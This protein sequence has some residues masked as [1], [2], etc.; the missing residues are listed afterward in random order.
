ML[1]HTC[2]A[3]SNASSS[4][5][6]FASK[7][8]SHQN[9]ISRSLQS[10]SGTSGVGTAT[11]IA[12]GGRFYVAQQSGPLAHSVGIIR[13]YAKVVRKL[14]SKKSS[15]SLSEKVAAANSPLELPKTLEEN[16]GPITPNDLESWIAKGEA[17]DAARREAELA[18]K[19]AEEEEEEDEFDDEDF[20]E[21]SGD[22]RDVNPYAKYKWIEEDGPEEIDP[23]A[24]W[25]RQEGMEKKRKR[26]PPPF[27]PGRVMLDPDD[28]THEKRDCL[29]EYVKK[30]GSEEETRH[31]GIVRRPV[32]LRHWGI[33]N[34]ATGD[35]DRVNVYKIIWQW[36]GPES[37]QLDLESA[38]LKI[39]ILKP[40]FDRTM[41]VLSPI[42]LWKKFAVRAYVKEKPSTRVVVP[43]LNTP[44]ASSIVVNPGEEITPTLKRREIAALP[45]IETKEDDMK[46]I[47]IELATKVLFAEINK[48][49]YKF[50]PLIL[51]IFHLNG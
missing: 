40:I 48:Y 23:D 43:N 45:A 14:K 17:E 26:S 29:V 12:S 10:L 39:D 33:V 22:G 3:L 25:Q 42:P 49:V 4:S 35:E 31:F 2:F 50:R 28:W 1:A 15:N 7:S 30:V 38:Q 27:A 16:F 44:R 41:K 6:R 13:G 47:P 46:F 37:T 36:H 9:G 21:F 11:R 34:L 20:G 24:P 5:A 18:A 32:G 19:R 8:A 51:V